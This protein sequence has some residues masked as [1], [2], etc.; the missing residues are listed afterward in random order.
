MIAS[1]L[2]NATGRGPPSPALGLVL[3]FSL[4]WAAAYNPVGQA[5][6]DK[7]TQEQLF[8][9]GPKSSSA[10]AWGNASSSTT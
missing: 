6:E 2:Q 8:N 1:C 10:G 3:T 7:G 4:I 5:G 9:S